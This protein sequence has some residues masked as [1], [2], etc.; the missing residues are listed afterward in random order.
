MAATLEGTLKA[1]IPV[2]PPNV[3]A[4]G[5]TNIGANQSIGPQAP[6]PAGAGQPDAKPNK[7]TGTMLN[8][9]AAELGHR[10]KLTECTEEGEKK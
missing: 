10:V 3:Q 5:N 4:G 2:V 1:V 9:V 7:L 6:P 8:W